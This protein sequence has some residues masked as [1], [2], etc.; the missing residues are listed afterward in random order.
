MSTKV[1][2]YYR[3]SRD[4]QSNY[5]IEAQQRA[6]LNYCKGKGYEIVKEYK[7]EGCSAS[8]NIN[9]REEFLEMIDDAKKKKFQIIV[10]HKI[11]RFSRG[12]DY[13]TA[14]YKHLLKQAGVKRESVTEQSIDDTPEG[15]VMEKML[16]IIA[17]YFSRNLSREAKKGQYENALK[18]KHNGGPTPLGYGVN[19]ETGEYII[20]PEEAKIVKKIYEMFLQGYGYDKIAKAFPTFMTKRNKPLGKGSIHDI[21]KN[22]KYTGVYIYNQSWVKGLN[23][24]MS[25]RIQKPLNEQVRIEGGMPLII[26]KATWLEVQKKMQA[27]KKISGSFKQDNYVYLLSNLL[28]CGECGSKLSG[29]CCRSHSKNAQ[30]I[31]YYECGGYK[32]YKNCS[33]KKVRADDLEEQVLNYLQKYFTKKNI[34]LLEKWIDYHTEM[35]NRDNE[36]EINKLKK[37][38]VSLNTKIENIVNL[39]IDTPSD[40]L[41]MKLTELEQEKVK[42]QVEI[43]TIQNSKQNAEK[44][45]EL[46]KFIKKLENIR[47]LDRQ[48]Q[49]SIIEYLIKKVQ[50]QRKS[51]SELLITI[52]SSL[53]NI[54]VI[55][56]DIN[57]LDF[58][59]VCDGSPKGNR[60]PDTTVKGW[61]LNRLTMGPHLIIF[62][63][64]NNK[65][66]IYS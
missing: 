2:C 28:K 58:S 10:V 32:R 4:G 8:K 52:I 12:D 54:L 31:Y 44:C 66:A 63:N 50:I 57:T 47:T 13:E 16:E 5:S 27:R 9:K 14:F 59:Q 45:T 35:L 22:E 61:C 53:K 25:N 49:K 26:D 43:N 36:E 41:K 21:L 40:S 56:N 46:K 51:N 34:E 30:T 23:G 3:Y 24:K 37:Y 48:N 6:C 42:I 19:K 65:G 29:T 62:R 60:T 1:A 18:G 17:H 39:L 7:D 33:T 55:Q 64:E 11:D 20:N 15:E 38:V